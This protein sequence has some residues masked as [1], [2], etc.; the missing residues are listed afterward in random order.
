MQRTQHLTLFS[1]LTHTVIGEYCQEGQHH[2]DTSEQSSTTLCGQH[3]AKWFTSWESIPH[4]KPVI[5]AV[6]IS[7][8]QGVILQVKGEEGQ[9]DIHAGGYNDDERALKVVRVLVWEAWWLYETRGTGEVTGT[10]RTW[11]EDTATKCIRDIEIIQWLITALK[12]QTVWITLTISL[13]C[14]IMQE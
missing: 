6:S 3:N 8:R 13:Q 7:S 5:L 1:V 11:G 10:V 12:P 14:I 4:F 2:Q 9:G